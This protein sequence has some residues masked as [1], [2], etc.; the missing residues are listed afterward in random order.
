MLLDRRT[1][2][3]GTTCAVAAAATPLPSLAE[4]A[5]SE[6]SLRG[7]A[8]AQ[9]LD[10]FRDY[11]MP[12]HPESGTYRPLVKDAEMIAEALGL[13]HPSSWHL[14]RKSDLRA[15]IRAYFAGERTFSI[16]GTDTYAGL[17]S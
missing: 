11:N 5:P 4:D 14:V 1:V 7:R 17:D 10:A 8:L 2:M 13:P 6:V 12:G 16:D 9:W 15:A 3:I